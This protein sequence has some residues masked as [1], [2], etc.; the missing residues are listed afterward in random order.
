MGV[1]IAFY[2]GEG[3]VPDKF[4][5]RELMT[6]QFGDDLGK[7]FHSLQLAAPFPVLSGRRYTI[8]CDTNPAMGSFGVGPASAY[9]RG[10]FWPLPDYAMRFRTHV[11]VV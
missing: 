6:F 11:L 8:W 3:V 2:E 4:L 7:T 5:T 1:S 9:T 10:R